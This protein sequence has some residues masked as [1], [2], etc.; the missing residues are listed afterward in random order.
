MSLQFHNAM[1]EPSDEERAELDEAH[2]RW[3]A[4]QE[5]D[6]NDDEF[7]AAN[8]LIDQLMQFASIT[9]EDDEEEDEEEDPRAGLPL[10]LAL[11]DDYCPKSTDGK[12]RF[13]EERTCT[14]CGESEEAP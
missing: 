5:G 11:D 14:A 1:L 9:A 8:L 6:S 2:A 10:I 3:L 13:G 4:A 7:A 12:H